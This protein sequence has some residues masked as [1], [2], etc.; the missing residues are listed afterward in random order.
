MKIMNKLIGIWMQRITLL[1]GETI[2]GTSWY[3]HSLIVPYPPWMIAKSALSNTLCWSTYLYTLT[4]LGR[5]LNMYKW[6]FSIDGFCFKLPLIKFG[7]RE[8]EFKFHEKAFYAGICVES[9]VEKLCKENEKN[10]VVY[11]TLGTLSHRYV[12]F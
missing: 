6:S 4:L 3:I 11:C 8:F 7:H 5:S 1:L 12:H 2:I 10:K 9:K